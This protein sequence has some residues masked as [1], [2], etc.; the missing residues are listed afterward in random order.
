MTSCSEIEALSVDGLYDFL[1]DTLDSDTMSRESIEEFRN[2][3]INGMS[4]L[5]LTDEE[6]KE[7]VPVLGERKVVKRLIYSMVKTQK[8]DGIPLS[9]SSQAVCD[10]STCIVVYN[11]ILSFVLF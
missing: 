4:F 5:T 1:W 11:I 3:R 8:Q 10:I 7:I 2:N 9:P 6:L